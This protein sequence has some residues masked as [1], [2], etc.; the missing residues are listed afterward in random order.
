MPRDSTCSI[1]HPQPDQTSDP[2]RRRQSKSTTTE[3]TITTGTPVPKVEDQSI[4]RASST[5]STSLTSNRHHPYASTSKSSSLKPETKP[6]PPPPPYSTRIELKKLTLSLL[7]ALKSDGARLVM[8]LQAD[9][10]RTTEMDDLDSDPEDEVLESLEKPT[11]PIN[12][13]A[14][15]REDSDDDD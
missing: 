8:T 12:V 2:R 11:V 14:Y 3:P 10:W 15:D 4:P 5:S 9:P 13:E 1:P 6:T 7:F